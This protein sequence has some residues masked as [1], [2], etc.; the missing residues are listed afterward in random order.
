V[1]SD[2]YLTS[3]AVQA[4]F[5]NFWA[6]T[7]CADGVGV[8]EHFARA[9]QHV[10]ARYA[11]EPAILGYDLFN[12]PAPGR[13]WLAAK[14]LMLAKFAETLA[15]RDGDRAPTA[16]ALATQWLDPKGRSTLMA[17]L[18]D[19]GLYVPTI[20]AAHP[21][22]AEF[23]RTKVMPMFQRVANAI[24]E[25]DKRHIL[26]LETSMSSNMGIYSA[27]EPVCGPNGQRDPRQAYAPHGYDIVVDT[28]DLATGS[29]DRVGLIFARHGETAER[30][31]MPML[32][33]EW[34]AYGHAGPEIRPAAQFVVRQFERLLCSDVYW[35]F[36]RDIDQRAYFEVLDRPFPLRVA[37]TLLSYQTDPESGGFTCVWQEDPSVTAPTRIYV[38]A[39]AFPG[40]DGVTLSPAGSGF[41]VEPAREG[42]R[43]VHLVVPPTG[44]SV[45]RRLSTRQP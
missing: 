44:A 20:E 2:A 36:V 39:R 34:G 31:G 10:A 29:N 26:F 23:E 28:A 18:A 25:V 45:E 22:F 8:Q 3:P 9:W 1:W 16:S 35:L 5:D 4:A 37:G 6:N 11:D 14:S 13:Q 27:I 15:E 32:V 19:M 30:L 41:R 42:A 38:P 40:E 33:G 43:S 12:E 7:P 24:R 17:Q 21:V